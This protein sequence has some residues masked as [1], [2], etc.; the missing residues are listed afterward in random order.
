MTPETFHFLRPVWLL[1]LVPIAALVWLCFHRSART[2]S[3]RRIVDEHLLRH[4]VVGGESRSN[5]WPFWALATAWVSTCV[6]LAGPTWA[7]LPQPL[8]ANVDPTVVVLDLSRSMEETDLAPSRRMRARYELQDVLDRLRGGQ[9]GLVVFSDEPF[10]ALPLT[11][12]DRVVSEWIPSLTGDLMPADGNRADRAIE[13]AVALLEQS[14]AGSGRILLLT[15]GLGGDSARAAEAAERAAALGHEV[16]VLG[17]APADAL[18]RPALEAIA[19]AGNGHY[20]T[21]AADDAD[22]DRVL[23]RRRAGAGLAEKSFAHADEWSDAG[24]WMLLIPVLLAPLAFRR[25]WLAALALGLA[26]APADRA[27]ASVWDDL[28][29]R[30]DQQGAAALAEGRSAAA[31]E[32]FEDPDW[33]AAAHYEAGRFDEAAESYRDLAGAESDYN[34]GNA[35]AR[36]G[37]LRGALAAYD[38][39]LAAKPEDQDAR[40]NRDLVER[41]L[42]EQEQERSDQQQQE[43]QRQQQEQSQ[44]GSPQGD[45][46]DP[47]A[48]GASSENQETASQAQPSEAGSQSADDGGGGQ[49]GAANESETDSSPGSPG[50]A[51]EQQRASAAESAGGQP[52]AG[53]E[54]G[55]ENMARPAEANAGADTPDRKATARGASADG[56]EPSAAEARSGESDATGSGSLSEQLAKALEGSDAHAKPDS[57]ESSAKERERAAGTGDGRPLS[58]EEQAREQRL[59]QVPDDPGGLLRA[60]IHRRYAEKRYAQEG[61]VPW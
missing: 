36:S 9:V 5:A 54:S 45:G 53:Q 2:S 17:T 44:S 58:E 59:R 24:V 32:L 34:L 25:G 42:R 38:D 37:D 14:G 56:A 35:L 11:D 57:G 10:V 33:K 51:A 8:F 12:D 18:D 22:L 27:D 49:Q 55:G 15:D 29:Q 4:L 20:A 30:R 13:Q 43:Q 1:A 3:W 23:V 19:A 48:G 41:L 47:K 61:L 46:G 52:S 16:S 21:A 39:A 7:R 50:E 28:W 6:A 26:L 31:A 40:F 60:K